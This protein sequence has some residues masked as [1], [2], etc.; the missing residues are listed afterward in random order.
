MDWTT[1]A[2]TKAGFYWLHEP[3]RPP[4]VVAVEFAPAGWVAYYYGSEEPCCPSEISA[5]ARWAGPILPPS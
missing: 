2:P 5:D 3:N 1:D 4:T